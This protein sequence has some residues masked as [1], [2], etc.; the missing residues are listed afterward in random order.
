SFP[1]Q[2]VARLRAQLLTGLAIRSQDTPEMASLAFDQMI[3]KDHPYSRPE[4]GYPETVQNISRED[5][6]SFHK[7]HYGPRG[8]VIAV[9]GAVAPG[10]AVRQV[11]EALG[12]WENPAQPAPPE[13]PSVT[14]LLDILT[15]R[16]EIP[17]KI[18]SDIVM[19]VAGPP[20]RS[21]DFFAAA[22]GNSVLGQ[23]GMMGR[24]GE[25]VRERAGL[26]YYAYSGVSGGLGPGPWSVAAG[27]NPDNIEQAI[28]LIREEI[29][30]FVTEPVTAEELC[31]SQSS[32][33]GRLPLALES[34]AGVAGALLNLERY[35]LGLDYYQRY[36][37]LVRA[38]TIEDV[39][40]TAQKY[41]D[42][43]KLAIAVAGP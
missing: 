7:S 3:Y 6:V 32:F 36:A 31:D 22:L 41:L 29:R 37:D 33:V 35:D 15:Q 24:I 40:A 11:A 25:S 1:G 27:V 4:D 39:L 17:G 43:D 13:L 26:A 10:E 9:V 21:S 42:P 12:D 23:F 30:R 34:N 28:E 14:P 16:V 5:L 38:V 19:G 20:R 2:Q 8:M 18:Q